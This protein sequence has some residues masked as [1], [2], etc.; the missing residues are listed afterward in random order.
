LA[1]R[2]Q[3]RQARARVT[4]DAILVGAERLLGREGPEA[5]TTNRIA[6][7]AGVSVGSVYQYFPNKQAIIAALVDV[8]VSRFF[9][10]FAAALEAS[11]DLPLETVGDTLARG[12]LELY[13]AN[14]RAHLPLYKQIS[15]LDLER[16]LQRQLARYV[17]VVRGF[18]VGRRDIDLR[19]VDADVA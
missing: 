5:L 4:R 14:V 10:F 9:E 1:P 8:Y 17:G 7:E 19:G 18:L 2:K 16:V 15:M 12:L 6:D 13:R 11:H 3:P